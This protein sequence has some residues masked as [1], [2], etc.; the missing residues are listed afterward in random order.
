MPGPTSE[1]A[2]IHSSRVRRLNNGAITVPAAVPS[3]LIMSTSP[4]IHAGS[5]PDFSTNAAKNVK[6]PTAPRIRPIAV[7]AVMMLRVCSASRSPTVSA[8]ATFSARGRLNAASI[9]R[10]KI[11]DATRSTQGACATRRMSAA[12][13]PA[14]IPPTMLMNARREFAST[15]SL[16]SLITLGTSALLVTLCVFESTSAANASGYSA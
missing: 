9:P 3:A 5:W 10:R 11:T 7:P 4:Y 14:A 8:F 1:P 15:S 2:R 16:L 13:G 6:K 12:T